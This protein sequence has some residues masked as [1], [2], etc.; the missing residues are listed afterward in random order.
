MVA[1]NYYLAVKSSPFQTTSPTTS[2]T[3]AHLSLLYD[4]HNDPKEERNLSDSPRY[5]NKLA[6]LKDRLLRRIIDNQQGQPSALVGKSFSLTSS[7]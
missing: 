4:L 3:E 5:Q 2:L 7:R 1:T 6:N